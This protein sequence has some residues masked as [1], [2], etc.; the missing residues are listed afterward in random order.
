MDMRDPKNLEIFY[1]SAI[2]HLSD[3]QKNKYPFKQEYTLNDVFRVLH[4][5]KELNYKNNF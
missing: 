3:E 4:S 2:S 5:I 1:N